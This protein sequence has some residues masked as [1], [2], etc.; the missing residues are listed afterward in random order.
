MQER[1]HLVGAGPTAGGPVGCQVGLPGL[2]VIFRVAAPGVDPLIELLG[3]AANLSAIPN[4]L[5]TSRRAKTPVSEDRLPPSNR[6]S[7]NLAETGDRPG[8]V[9]VNSRMAGVVPR[10]SQFRRQHPNSTS[11]QRVRATFASLAN[12]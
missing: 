12:F 2:D 5:S 10:I 6:A 4:R 11:D 7:I 3:R 1:P 8:R 9:C